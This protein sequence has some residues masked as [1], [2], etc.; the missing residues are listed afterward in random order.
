MA[1]NVHTLEIF[2]DCGI[3]F[4]PILNNHN[5]TTLI[6]QQVMIFISILKE[7]SQ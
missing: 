1:Y 5:L 7:I 6:N 2:D 4:R 3:L